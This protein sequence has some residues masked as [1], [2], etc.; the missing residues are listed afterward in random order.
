L[1]IAL[2]CN[3][4][5]ALILLAVSG[6]LSSGGAF[7]P[8]AG[9]R[10]RALAPQAWPR[11]NYVRIFVARVLDI[12][13]QAAQCCVSPEGWLAHHQKLSVALKCEA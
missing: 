9:T 10:S 2:R 1:F 4:H 12:G 7:S 8:A 6:L 11:G 5:K 13:A 3:K